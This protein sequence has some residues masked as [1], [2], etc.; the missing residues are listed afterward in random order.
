MSNCTVSHW[1]HL[2]SLSVCWWIMR[3]LSLKVFWLA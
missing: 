3:L 1:V 2:S